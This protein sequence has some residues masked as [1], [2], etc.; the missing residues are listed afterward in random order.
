M[1]QINRAAAILGVGIVVLISAPLLRLTQNAPPVYNH[2]DR[3]V[4]RVFYPYA[5]EDIYGERHNGLAMCSGVIVSRNLILTVAHIAT[6]KP[7]GEF[8][9]HIRKGRQVHKVQ[10][11]IERHDTR[12]DLL[13]LRLEKPID[14]TPVHLADLYEVGEHIIFC[15][16]NVGRLTKFRHYRISI[17][18][19]GILLHPVYYGDSGGGVF[20]TR[21]E[22]VGIIQRLV[23]VERGAHTMS[24]LV[25]YAM[26]VDKIRKFW[27]GVQ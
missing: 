3:N 27:D 15:G 2:I 13:L 9:V 24:S 5:L 14:W 12:K 19:Y 10:A 21:G 6:Q 17:N 25:G 7:M 1:K 20:N 11:V 23:L 16:C 26:P 4:V 18:N 8:Y 22:L